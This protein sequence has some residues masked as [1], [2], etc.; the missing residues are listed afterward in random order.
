MAL[1]EPKDTDEVYDIDGFK[2]IVN[3]DFLEKAK[4]IKVDFLEIGFKLTSSLE[5]Q[6]GCQGCDTTATSS[7]ST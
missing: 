3:K 4:P 5:L 1:D 7:C 2:Y 6:A